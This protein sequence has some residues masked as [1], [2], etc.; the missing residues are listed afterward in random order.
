MIDGLDRPWV[1][2]R[3]RGQAYVTYTSVMNVSR[4][5]F[6][7]GRTWSTTTPDADGPG[8]EQLDTSLG[9]V[10]QVQDMTNHLEMWR[11]QHD[12]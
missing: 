8:Q 12:F 9:D 6:D 10:V 4:A 11:S 2:G 5:I 7:F 3:V 1:L